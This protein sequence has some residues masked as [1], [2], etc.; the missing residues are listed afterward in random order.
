MG[1]GGWCRLGLG[2][3]GE[4]GAP[5][6]IRV[7]LS[8]ES[9]LFFHYMHVIDESGFHLVQEQQKLVIDFREYP[10]VLISMLNNTIKDPHQCVARCARLWHGAC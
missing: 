10:S 4:E 2:E 3:Q 8:S 7:E 1:T 6:S 9:D 5:Q